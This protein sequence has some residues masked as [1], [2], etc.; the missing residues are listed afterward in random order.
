MPLFAVI[1]IS[2]YLLNCC[3]VNARNQDQS[4]PAGHFYQS[5]KSGILN[6]ATDNAVLVLGSDF[7]YQQANKYRMICFNFSGKHFEVVEQNDFDWTKVPPNK[8]VYRLFYDTEKGLSQLFKMDNTTG[9]FTKINEMRYPPAKAV[10]YAEMRTI[11]KMF[12]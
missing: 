10:T 3:M 11:R 7:F 8:E 1:I 9:A 12:F 4:V 5:I 2:S 6:P